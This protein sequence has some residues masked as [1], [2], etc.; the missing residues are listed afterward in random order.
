MTVEPNALQRVLSLINSAAD[1]VVLSI[2]L[3]VLTI[4]ILP[5]TQRSWAYAACGI[6]MGVAGGLAARWFG[7]SEGWVIIGTL[8]GVISGPATVI[9]FQN[10]TVSEVFEEIKALREGRRS[11]GEG[12]S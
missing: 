2:L 3:V 8:V 6:G 9:Y 12:E 10:K 5:G 1:L 4:F 7:L 11:G